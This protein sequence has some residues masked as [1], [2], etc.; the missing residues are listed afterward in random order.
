MRCSFGCEGD[1]KCRARDRGKTAHPIAG[2][3]AKGIRRQ[4]L[5]S[6]RLWVR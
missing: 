1:A 4:S 3:W 5:K 6:V 2:H